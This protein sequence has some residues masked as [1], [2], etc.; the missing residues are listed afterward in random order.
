MNTLESLKKAYREQTEI[1]EK[2]LSK[3]I[4]IAVKFKKQY[5]NVL[6]QR[7]ERMK[8]INNGLLIQLTEY[9]QVD[10]VAGK[11]ATVSTLQN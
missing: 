10:E 2:Q 8:I 6:S 9:L 3:T 11:G 4:E 1:L 7:V 5:A